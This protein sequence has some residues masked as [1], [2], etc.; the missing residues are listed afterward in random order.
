MA[1]KIK[2]TTNNEFPL[3][4]ETKTSIKNILINSFKFLIFEWRLFAVVLAFYI[5]KSFILDQ[6]SSINNDLTLTQQYFEFILMQLPRIIFDL[7]FWIGIMPIIILSGKEYLTR[8]EKLRFEEHSICI[9]YIYKINIGIFQFWKGMM[10]RYFVP[11]FQYKSIFSVLGFLMICFSTLSMYNIALM[12]EPDLKIIAGFIGIFEMILGF[13]LF[14]APVIIVLENK[15][16]V[17]GAKKSA[18]IVRKKLKEC[19]IFNI[20]LV[21]INPFNILF[22]AIII[23]HYAAIPWFNYLQL[24]QVPGFEFFQLILSS[25]WFIFCNA[26]IIGFYL[27]ISEERK[28]IQQTR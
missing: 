10:G 13:I 26:A 25:G 16:F 18:H 21:L 2:N 22:L 5:F 3:Y 14:L 19:I 24:T 17:D 7:L 28:L 12:P 8:Q 9:S 11:L 20:I 27:S 15:T 1:L 23:S 6:N 4:P